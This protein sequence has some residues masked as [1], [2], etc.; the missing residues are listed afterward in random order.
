MERAQ[1][2]W[3]S[4]G[5]IEVPTGLSGCPTDPVSCFPLTLFQRTDAHKLEVHSKSHPSVLNSSEFERVSV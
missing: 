4:L 5:R 3:P 1:S 2:A